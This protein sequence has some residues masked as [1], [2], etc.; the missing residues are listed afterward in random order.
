MDRIERFT[1]EPSLVREVMGEVVPLGLLRK[2]GGR[3][4]LNM[5]LLTLNLSRY[6]NGVAK[7]HMEVS[8]DMFPGYEIHAITNGVH[9]YTW[10][11]ESFRRLYDTTDICLD[12]LMSLSSLSG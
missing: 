3:D 5:T 9:S 6:I 12:W 8:R 7:R 1:R 11:C 4:H 2:L 10:T